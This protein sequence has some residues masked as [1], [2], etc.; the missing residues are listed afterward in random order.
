MS[1]KRSLDHLALWIER[2][3][4]VPG[5]TL[6]LWGDV[7]DDML[8]TCMTA[9]HL[10][11]P[12][13][14]L[15]ILMNSHGGE[16]WAGMAIFDLIANHEG[17]ITMKVIGSACSMAFVILQAADQREAV[18]HAVL[19]HHVGSSS[20]PE[21]HTKNNDLLYEFN[22]KHNHKIDEVVLARLNET[23]K[24]RGQKPMTMRQWKDRDIWDRWMGPE[25]AIKLGA[26]DKII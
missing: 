16:T 4:D 26:L 2:G 15:T 14:D 11:G 22:K 12:Q 6:R 1:R 21:Q 23:L 7:D 17:H 25:E 8:D 5:K 9:F 18:E 19:M 13:T 20:L 3:I 10:F 24:S